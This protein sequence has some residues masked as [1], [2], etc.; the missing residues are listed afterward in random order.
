MTRI[1]LF[2]LSGLVMLLALLAATLVSLASIE[3]YPHTLRGDEMR[4]VGAATNFIQEFQEKNARNPNHAES[5]QWMRKMDKS[6]YR[7]D[8][9][10]FSINDHC[11]EKKTDYCLTFW[12]GEAFATYRSWEKEKGFVATTDSGS[13]LIPRFQFTICA[14][15][16]ALFSIII[17]LAARGKSVNAKQPG[18]ASAAVNDGNGDSKA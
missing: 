1:V 6:G 13:S 17:F 15:G 3:S 14:I 16:L 4:H 8:G 18:R 5:A 9:I 11:S 10:G 12:T 7:F 2:A